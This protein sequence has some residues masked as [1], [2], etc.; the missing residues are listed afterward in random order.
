MGQW[1]DEEDTGDDLPVDNGGSSTYPDTTNWPSTTP[2]INGGVVSTLQPAGGGNSP[3][4]GASPWGAPDD[5][6]D[7][8]F[9]G[10]STTTLVL[11]GAVF[12]G[13]Y[14][15]FPERRSHDTT[16]NAPTE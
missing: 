9:A 13:A 16:Q 12:I 6:D 10:F 15:L 7:S 11:A 5:G 1:T 3:S 4:S 8:T 14:I 2:P